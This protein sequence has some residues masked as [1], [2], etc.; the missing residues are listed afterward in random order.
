MKEYTKEEHIGGS[1][2][3]LAI[4]AL[5]RRSHHCE[6]ANGSKISNWLIRRKGGRHVQS[7]AKNALA[8]SVFKIR[9]CQTR[10]VADASS[11]IS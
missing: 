11:W 1:Q 8:L 10:A 2:T 4:C 7:V 5:L 6:L 3:Y 9:R